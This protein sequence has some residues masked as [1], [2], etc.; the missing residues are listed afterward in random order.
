MANLPP[1]WL[2]V[3]KIHTAQINYKVLEIKS[4]AILEALLKWEDKLLG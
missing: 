3:K 4:I 2:Y 1:H